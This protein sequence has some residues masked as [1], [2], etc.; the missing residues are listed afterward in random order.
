MS[1]IT[2]FI[3]IKKK[4]GEE[5]KT[6]TTII[7]K[8]IAWVHGIVSGQTPRLFNGPSALGHT[9]YLFF[10]ISSLKLGFYWVFY[11]F[12]FILSFNF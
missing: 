11:C 3:Y 12:F 10:L 9:P 6:T 7:K 4:Q 1:S 8:N 5:L 2:F